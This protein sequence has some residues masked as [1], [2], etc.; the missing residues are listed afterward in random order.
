MKLNW[1]PRSF[2]AFSDGKLLIRAYTVFA[3]AA[4]L[5]G[6]AS[7]QAQPAPGTISPP[8]AAKTVI[9]KPATKAKSVAKQ[10]APTDSGPCQL[11]VIP[12]IGDQFVVQKIGITIFG[13]EQTEVPIDGW[14]L[15]DLAVARVRAAA[16]GGAVRRIAYAKGAFETYEHPAPALFRNSRD[17]LT[18]IVRQIT[19]N[20]NCERYVVVTKFTGKLEGTN[21]TLHGIGILQSSSLFSRTSLF[22]N[23]QVTVFDGQTFAIHK[24]PFDLGS[25][26]SGTLDRM[27]QDPLSE[28]DKTSFP[29]PA[30]AAVNSVL[31]RDHTRTLVAAKLDKILPAS[32]KV[33]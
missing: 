2:F 25:V 22:A 17:D 29:E 33:E 28:L 8:A 1:C 20:A 15:D 24:I 21:Q 27:T 12:V 13:N 7:A 10:S 3:I 11:G 5:A 18:A 9:K 31:L 16:A 4:W 23:V 26:L 6:F 30:A 19:A 14:G 32:L